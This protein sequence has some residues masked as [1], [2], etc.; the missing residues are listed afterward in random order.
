MNQ[1]TV[2][3]KQSIDPNDYCYTGNVA[4]DTACAF[5]ALTADPSIKVTAEQFLQLYVGTMLLIYKKQISRRAH[6]DLKNTKLM[7]NIQ[8]MGGQY[9][10]NLL[11]NRTLIMQVA[12]F[13]SNDDNQFCY[14]L[15][16]RLIPL[17]VQLINISS[18]HV[19]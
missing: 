8:K 2:N 3:L 10:I 9:D 16:S 5:I 14:E 17:D 19:N 18:M 1:T 7:K 12:K 13:L 6:P 15:Q 11:T 4:A